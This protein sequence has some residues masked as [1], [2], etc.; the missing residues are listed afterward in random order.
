MDLP[1]RW[2]WPPSTN[3]SRLDSTIRKA[4]P[5]DVRVLTRTLTRAFDSDPVLNWM[6]R[7]DTKR[8]RAFLVHFE[9]GLRQLAMPHG[10]VYVT[11]NLRGVAVCVPSDKW[12]PRTQDSLARLR[13]QLFVT[14]PGHLRPVRAALA[15]LEERRP[16]RPHLYFFELAV[17]PGWQGRGI[18][19]SLL[20]H[21]LAWC[22]RQGIGAYLE[23]TKAVNHRLYER[24]GFQLISSHQLGSDGPSLWL[25]WRE[26]NIVHTADKV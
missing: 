25:M 11:A 24:Y 6:I 26:A 3:S 13:A 5:A 18:G 22:D 2:P 10:H 8:R 23:N 9:T 4:T 17:D 21:A 14:G 12:R 15:G 19:S 16:T 20:S 7:Q 1:P